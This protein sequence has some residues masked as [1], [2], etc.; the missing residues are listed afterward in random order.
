MLT[1]FLCIQ[2]ELI[3]VADNKESVELDINTSAPFLVKV[4][5]N[6]G[7]LK[8]IN[9]VTVFMQTRLLPSAQ[10]R[11]ALD[12]MIN[13]IQE[14]KT[15]LGHV[16]YGCTFT[17]SRTLAGS[18]LAPDADFESGVVKI[19]NGAENELILLQ[20]NV[21]QL[22]HWQEFVTRTTMVMILQY[23]HLL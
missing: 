2:D 5:K 17:A 20:M 14:N 4:R 3:E 1:H 13:Q 12:M 7:H 11:G 15:R 22:N 6:H 19:Q 9:P 16:L 21:W 8:E 23:L 18:H 10:C